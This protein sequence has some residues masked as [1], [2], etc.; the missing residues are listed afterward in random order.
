MKNFELENDSLPFG[1][2]FT[3]VTCRT[4]K[5]TFEFNLKTSKFYHV[6]KFCSDICFEAY[7]ER[8]EIDTINT[9]KK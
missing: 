4:C 6:D 3:I 9:S 2:E 8:Y 5:K 1:I 7:A